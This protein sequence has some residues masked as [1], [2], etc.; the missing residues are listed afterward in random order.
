MPGDQNREDCVKEVLNHSKNLFIAKGFNVVIDST[1]YLDSLRNGLLSTGLPEKAPISPK[2]YLIW[3]KASE[4]CLTKRNL[5]RGRTRDTISKWHGQWQNP[6]ANDN[7]TL[8]EFENNS[9]QDLERIYK[10]LD[11]LFENKNPH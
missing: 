2:K 3:I 10:K 11:N 1:A 7:Y 6:S 8:L 5:A 4:E 9:L